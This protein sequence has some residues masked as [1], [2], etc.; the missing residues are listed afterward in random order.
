MMDIHGPDWDTHTIGG[1]DP[2]S[3]VGLSEF[4][5]KKGSTIKIKSVKRTNEYV[6]K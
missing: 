5:I 4:V 2:N 6:N 3:D 1:G